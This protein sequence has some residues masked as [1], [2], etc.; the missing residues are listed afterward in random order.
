MGQNILNVSNVSNKTVSAFHI[1]IIKKRDIIR[2]GLSI[3]HIVL[4]MG[5]GSVK[6][7]S[8]ITF[9]NE[10]R[11]A[12][13]HAVPHNMSLAKHRTSTAINSKAGELLRGSSSS[14]KEVF[15]H[16]AATECLADLKALEEKLS[17]NKSAVLDAMACPNPGDTKF[18]RHILLDD[19]NSMADKAV[20]YAESLLQQGALRGVVDE[21]MEKAKAIKKKASD[22]RN[23]ENEEITAALLDVLEAYEEKLLWNI[24]AIT[25]KAKEDTGYCIH[26]FPN[27]ES[28][29]AE[30]VGHAEA[31]LQ[32][33][34]SRGIID[35][36]KKKAD[37]IN[38]IEKEESDLRNVAISLPAD[39]GN[40][41]A[42]LLVP[43]NNSGIAFPVLGIAVML[44]SLVLLPLVNHSK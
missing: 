44:S 36:I 39:G 19:P 32:Q 4:L 20:R 12:S 23:L 24:N 13:K 8:V 22:L 18:C 31:L 29:T 1:I 9:P 37:T 35:K 21:I 30:V 7:S 3:L 38:T 34:V 14:N 42:A 40:N 5:C 33:G 16:V 43:E 27:S 11:V 15:L 2:L 26:T 10:I 17:W 41:E 28:I 6:R 25:R